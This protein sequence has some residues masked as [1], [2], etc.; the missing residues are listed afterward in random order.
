MS[1]CVCAAVLGVSLSSP[2]TSAVLTETVTGTVASVSDNIGF[3]G[4]GRLP[5]PPVNSP[6]VFQITYDTNLGTTFLGP[7]SVDLSGGS[8][9]LN[10]P[11]PALFWS[12]TANGI[13]L[14]VQGETDFQ[15]SAF[16]QPTFS[17]IFTSTPE[18]T[19]QVTST[20]DVFPLSVSTPFS[21]ILGTATV[22][23]LSTL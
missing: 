1:N 18:F 12:L 7:T 4:Q 6:F 20:S 10:G 15:Q 22:R 16:K 14:P 5:F 8:S 21:H 3:F 13:S 11:S 17:E 23:L 2:A 9:T 19:V